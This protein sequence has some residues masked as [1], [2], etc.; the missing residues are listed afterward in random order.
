MALSFPLGHINSPVPQGSF[1][2][3][4]AGPIAADIMIPRTFRAI[5]RF[6]VLR[7]PFGTRVAHTK[8]CRS[9][10]VVPSRAQFEASA[11]RRRSRTRHT[12]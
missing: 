5:R 3:A 9:L 4:G 1:H 12:R 10:T 11:S 7:V 8:F 6:V 2:A